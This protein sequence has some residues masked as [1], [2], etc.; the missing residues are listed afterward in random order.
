GQR[1]WR[2]GKLSLAAEA[3]YRPTGHQHLQPRPDLEQL[4]DQRRGRDDLFKVIKQQ[5]H[6]LVPQFVFEALQQWSTTRFSNL[7]RLGNGRG[8]QAR[9]GDGRQGHEKDTVLE[10]FDQFG[11]GLQGQASL[12]CATRAGQRQQAHIVPPKDLEHLSQFLLT[13]DERCRL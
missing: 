12:T 8:D 4:S 7:E 10:G 13:T 6:L 1:Q 2:N 5:Q 3:Q 9:V 11:R